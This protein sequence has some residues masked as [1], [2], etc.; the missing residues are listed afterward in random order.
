M[1]PD[2]PG[3]AAVLDEGCLKAVVPRQ[4][5]AC[6]LNECHSVIER[7][8]GSPRHPARQI[9]AVVIYDCVQLRRIGLREKTKPPPLGELD[10]TCPVVGFTVARSHRPHT[11]R[12]AY[13]R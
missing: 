12:P 11:V 4:L 13:D 9:V 7:L 2:H 8:A 6:A 1:K 5:V 10:V 3:D